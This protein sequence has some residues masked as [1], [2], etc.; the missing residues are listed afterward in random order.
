[1]TAVARTLASLSE[2]A[3]T[4]L[5]ALAGFAGDYPNDPITAD[6]V[7]RLSVLLQLLRAAG[8]TWQDVLDL[9]ALHDDDLDTFLNPWH[10]RTVWAVHGGTFPDSPAVMEAAAA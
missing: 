1:M 10:A 5:W 3:R 6:A 9:I 2:E 8:G 7:V 4:A